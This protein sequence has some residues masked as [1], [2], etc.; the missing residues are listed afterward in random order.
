MLKNANVKLI[1]YVKVNETDKKVFKKVV[2]SVIRGGIIKPIE[3]AIL[4]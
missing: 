2:I 1:R 3:Y 4:I